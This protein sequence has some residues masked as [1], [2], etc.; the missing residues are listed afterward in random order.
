LEA[1]TRDELLPAF[2]FTGKLVKLWNLPVNGKKM[3]KNKNL[4]ETV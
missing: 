4:V 2:K 1:A 3:V